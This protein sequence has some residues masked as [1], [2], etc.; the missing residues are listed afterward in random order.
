MTVGEENIMGRL[1]TR[2]DPLDD[3][4]RG[5]FVRP[6][7]FGAASDAPRIKMDVKKEGR[8]FVLHAE[9]PGIKKEELHV[10][11]GGSMVSISAERKKRK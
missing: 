11:V 8:A 2:H 3:L 4:F 9:I 7:D 5:F 6:V 1:L 10:S